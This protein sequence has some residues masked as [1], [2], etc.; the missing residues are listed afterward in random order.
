MEQS[1]GGAHGLRRL[2]LH[3]RWPA[4]SATRAA[5]QTRIRFFPIRSAEVYSPSPLTR[6]AWIQ[7]FG[8]SE[9]QT[10]TKKTP[11]A[12][13]VGV[14]YGGGRARKRPEILCFL[15]WAAPGAWETLPQG[16]GS[17]PPFWQDFQGFRV[18]QS[19]KIYNLRSYIVWL[20]TIAHPQYAGT[21][22]SLAAS[23]KACC[24]CIPLSNRP[25]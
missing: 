19:H 9:A 5:K 12:H 1:G 15:T 4:G 24:L 10:H 8:K 16:G 22:R 20:L 17:H 21:R 18:A 6:S 23:S 14:A 7:M 2:T 13:G 25:R 3:C 11:P